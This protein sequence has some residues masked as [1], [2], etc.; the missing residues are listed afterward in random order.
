MK[1]KVYTRD[2]LLIMVAAFFYMC[3]SMSTAP[4]VAGYAESIGASGV[5]MG[6]I[7]ALITAAAVI[8]H[9][10]PNGLALPSENDISLTIQEA[11]TLGKIGV[12]LID[13]IIVADTDFV[14]MAQS[15][16]YG[17]IFASK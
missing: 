7:S 1:T 16:Q 4:I 6:I 9:N 2:V 3:C 11:D 13:H 10:H 15:E 5:W 8:C 14:S 12:Q 17:Y